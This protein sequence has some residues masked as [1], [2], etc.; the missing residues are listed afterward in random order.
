MRQTELIFTLSNRVKASG[1][2]KKSC[3]LAI[4][5]ILG[6]TKKQLLGVQMNELVLIFHIFTVAAGSLLALRLGKA[7]L[8]AFISICCILANLFV[9]KQV[10]LFGL[11]AT[12]AD[13]L[14]VGAALGLNIM[15]EYFGKKAARSAIWIS[16]AACSFYTI[17]TQIHLAYEPSAFDITHGHYF[18]LLSTMP[19]I[20]IASL[21][22]YAISQYADYALFRQLKK[23][24]SLPFAI[25]S[26]LSSTASQFLD[27]IIFTLLGLYGIVENVWHI[28]L[29][30]FFIKCLILIG[31]APFLALARKLISPEVSYE[32]I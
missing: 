21:I 28:I 17:L 20:I 3:P 9:A 5:G 23:L 30:S 18:M 11:T 24:T 14:A 25:R 8:T 1:K 6:Y 12:A 29:I 32:R 16:F 31:A 22:S 7:A 26:Y 2:T 15:Q 10:N 27:T 13:A 19:R 4:F